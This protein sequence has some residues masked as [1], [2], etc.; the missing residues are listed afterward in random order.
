MAFTA[1]LFLYFRSGLYQF[2]LV[3]VLE[4]TCATWDFRHMLIIN[5][6]SDESFSSRNQLK[7]ALRTNFLN[8]NVGAVHPLCTS[9]LFQS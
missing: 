3:S 7:N 5:Y 1:S 2:Y 9:P 6:M 4:V 8:V